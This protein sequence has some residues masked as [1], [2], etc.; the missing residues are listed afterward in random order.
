[1]LLFTRTMSGERIVI[2]SDH[3]G[4]EL[5]NKLVEYLKGKGIIVDDIGTYSAESTDYPDYGHALA[6]K[7]SS[8][9][10]YAG[11]SLCGSG[12]GIN[13]TANKHPE[14]RSALCWRKDIAELARRHNDANVCALPARFISLEEACEIVDTFLNAPFDGG[15]HERRKEKIPIK[16]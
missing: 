9:K 10:Y 2:A 13:I 15:R 11:I 8:G 16:K 4:F 3:A 12:N 14:I 1:M 6:E 7:V 5:K